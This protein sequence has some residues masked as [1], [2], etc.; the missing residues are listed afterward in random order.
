M[1]LRS[2]AT[3]CVSPGGKFKE[4]SLIYHPWMLSFSNQQSYWERYIVS[5]V[6]FI[7]AEEALRSPL[8]SQS[9][10]AADQMQQL[11]VLW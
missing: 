4:K 5:K 7:S 11:A 1:F 10:Q 8:V 6:S 3:F 9:E 2:V